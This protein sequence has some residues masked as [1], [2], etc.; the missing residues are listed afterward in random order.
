MEI[1][2]AVLACSCVFFQEFSDV[3]TEATN[4]EYPQPVIIIRGRKKLLKM[5][6]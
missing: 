3:S 5:D 1:Y 4:T 6:I 2:L